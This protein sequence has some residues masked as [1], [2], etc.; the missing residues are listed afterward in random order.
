MI[1]RKIG[2]TPTCI[3][4]SRGTQGHTVQEVTVTRAGSSVRFTV[5]RIDRDAVTVDL[6]AEEVAALHRWLVPVPAP[7]RE[8]GAAGR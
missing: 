2:S 6:D 5:R 4:L 8:D 3:R 7:H 1:L